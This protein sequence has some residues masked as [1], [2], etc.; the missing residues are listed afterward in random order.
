MKLP[1]WENA[2]IDTRKLRDY[3][4]SPH[5]P[6]GG[7]K[8][9]FFAQVGFDQ[10]NWR[11][12]EAAIREQIVSKEARLGQLS[13]YGR[14]YEIRAPLTGPNGRTVNTLSVWIVRT[15]EEVPRLV[16]ILPGEKE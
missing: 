14:K 15:S 2:V 5:H 7:P 8:A 4:L 9:Q 3:A 6:V 13:D 11:E 12:F 1:H 16:T 10:S